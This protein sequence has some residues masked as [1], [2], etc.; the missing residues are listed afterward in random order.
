MCYSSDQTITSLPIKW[1]FNNLCSSAGVEEKQRIRTFSLAGWKAVYASNFSDVAEKWPG[2]CANQLLSASYMS[3]QAGSLP[4]SLRPRFLVLEDE[5]GPA[6]WAALQIASF[7][8]AAH[9]REE[10]VWTGTW[11]YLRRQAA[12][13]GSFRLLICGN[14]FSVG[15]NGW[16][17]RP[18]Y[19]QN[20]AYIPVLHQMLKQVAQWENA[21]I[22]VY[23]DFEHPV[24]ALESAGC[25]SFSFQPNMVMPLNAEWKT[26]ED[27]LEAMTSKYRVRAR[28]AFRKAE[29]LEFRELSLPEIAWNAEKLVGLYREVVGTAGFSLATAGSPF[30]PGMKAALGSAYRLVGVYQAG[31][32]IA[33]YTTIYHGDKLEAHFIGFRQVCNKSCQLYLNMLYQMVSDGIRL[34]VSEIIFARTAL[35]IKSS[36]GA[37]ARPAFVYMQHVNPMLNKLLPYAVRWMEPTESWVPRHPFQE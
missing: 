19:A 7:D 12:R 26:P 16:M 35:E 18:D 23:K 34:K 28:R 30:F 20:E 21:Q 31:E 15:E 17:V 14:L 32:L 27:Y 24:Q 4:A 33:F 13:L 11:G 5:K 37:I 9:I 6:V 8:A 29:E 10:S 25:H 22:L 2:K 36:V 3:G 1:P